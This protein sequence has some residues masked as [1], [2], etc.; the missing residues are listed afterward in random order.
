MNIRRGLMTM[1][2]WCAACS[3][4]AAQL[5]TTLDMTVTSPTGAITTADP[6][7]ILAM[8]PMDV[9][10]TGGYEAFSTYSID[11]TTIAWDIWSVPP[12]PDELVTQ[13]LTP[14]GHL[15]QLPP[16]APGDYQ[17]NASWIHRG[18][19]PLEGAPS[20]GT[21]VLNF[22]VAGLHE[23]QA[24]DGD[25]DDDGDVDGADL[26]VWQASLG[27]ATEPPQISVPGD[28]DHD[29][30]VEGDDLAVWQ[31]DFIAASGAASGAAIAATPEPG[32]LVMVVTCFVVGGQL[33]RRRRPGL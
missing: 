24:Y 8:T 20:S 29:G 4:C 1:A 9:F 16:L 17:V 33:M 27:M 21:G 31:S 3:F 19:Q 15:T 26:L 10:P 25:Y 23:T 12:S 18:E 14:L 6:I 32:T 7:E 13:A 2:A 22:T 28:G 11:G 30:V 5:T